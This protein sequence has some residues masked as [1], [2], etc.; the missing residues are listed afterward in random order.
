M[1]ACDIE[2][3][4]GKAMA[5]AIRVASNKEG[6]GNKEGNGVGDMGGVR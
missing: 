1:V 5:K 2:G 6:D 3:K 4:G